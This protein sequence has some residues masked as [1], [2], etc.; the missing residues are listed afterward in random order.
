MAPRSHSSFAIISRHHEIWYHPNAGFKYLRTKSSANM[1]Y[2]P[3]YLAQRP[4]HPEGDQ[5][6][7]T[8]AGYYYKLQIPWN[9]C[10]HI[11]VL[12]I[13][14]QATADLTKRKPISRDSN[15]PYGLCILEVELEKRTQVFEMKCYK[16][17]LNVWYKNH[18]T[19]EE[20]CRKIPAAT[21]EY[22]EL[23]ILMKKQKL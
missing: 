22:N 20:V 12:S 13:I 5:G 16:R 4:A 14:A 3:L 15:I 7:R 10:F 2:R 21:E 1:I 6:K 9:S 11:E 17:L 23:L 18:K 8:E 19:C